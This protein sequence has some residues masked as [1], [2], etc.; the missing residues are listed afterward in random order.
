MTE[1]DVAFEFIRLAYASIAKAAIIPMQDI[2][3]LDAPAR[4]NIPSA[5][6]SNWVEIIAG[7][8]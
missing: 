5:T 6:E 4:M 3:N 1:E 7:A 2:L 8:G